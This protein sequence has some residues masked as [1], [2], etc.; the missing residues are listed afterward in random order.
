MGDQDFTV[1]PPGFQSPRPQPGHSSDQGQSQ[2]HHDGNDHGKGGHGKGGRD[3]GGR[4]RGGRDRRGHRRGHSRSK[5]ATDDVTDN[6]DYVIQEVD[7]AEYNFTYDTGWSK[8]S[9]YL[10]I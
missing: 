10:N 4:D 9:I 3:R 8:H 2:D 1:E 7:R 6:G 5:R